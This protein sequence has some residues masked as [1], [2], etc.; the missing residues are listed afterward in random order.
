MAFLKIEV[1][2][3]NGKDYLAELD[4]LYANAKDLGY[5]YPKHFD[6]YDNTQRSGKTIVVANMIRDIAQG[7]L[8]V[9]KA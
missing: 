7:K 1:P 6:E 5:S 9:V 4:V 2:L 8:K 3:A